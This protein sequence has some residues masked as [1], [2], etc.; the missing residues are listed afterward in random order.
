MTAAFFFI[1]G[2]TVLHVRN[3]APEG[4]ALIETLSGSPKTIGPWAKSLFLFGSFVVLFS[5]LFSPW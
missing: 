4:M 3:E 1:L 2:A 5:T